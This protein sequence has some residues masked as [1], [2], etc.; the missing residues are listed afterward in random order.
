M[1]GETA[2]EKLVDIGRYISSPL[3]SRIYNL[4]D[5]P[6]GKVLSLHRLN[7]AYAS[8]TS[9]TQYTNFFYT[10]LEFLNIDLHINASDIQKIPSAGPLVVVANHP[11]GGLDGIILGAI[12]TT[13]RPD[14]KILGNYMLRHIPELYEFV[15]PIDPF[16]KKNSMLKNI[17][18][19]KQ[20]IDWLQ[21]GGALGTFP[22]GEVSHFKVSRAQVTDPPWTPHVGSL[23][24][25]TGAAVLPVFFDGRNSN[26]FH[27]LGLLHPR[28]RTIMLPRELLNKKATSIKVHIGSP[29]TFRT[30]S[31]FDTNQSMADYLRLCTYILKNRDNKPFS[32]NLP[33]LHP[34][35]KYSKSIVPPLSHTMLRREIERLTDEQ[36]LLQQGDISVYIARGDQIPQILLEIGRLR[37]KTFREAGEGT[38]KKVDLDAFD[39]SYLQLFMWN[40]AEQEIV[41]GYRLAPIDQIIASFGTQGLYTTTL[42]RFKNGFLQNLSPAL[43]LGRSFI[44]SHY[45][46][47]YNSLALLWRGIGEFIT[48]NPQY[49]ILF[50]PVSISNDYQTVSRNL[51]LQFLQ[52]SKV[53]PELSRYVKARNPAR[54][55]KIRGVDQRTLQS[56]FLTLEHVSA[57]VSEIEKDGKGVPILLRHYLKLNGTILSFN[58]DADFS[59][60]I[61]SLLIVDLRKTETKLLKRFMNEGGLKIFLKYHNIHTTGDNNCPMQEGQALQ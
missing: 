17:K 42:F 51:I 19:L 56:P 1:I 5:W 50:G 28:F 23:I 55:R 49:K 60:V 54:N 7:D 29:I 15:I 3:K 37:E 40:H 61:D 13:V 20:T 32:F 30:L 4:F 38:G 14:V 44:C 39:R 31:N 9:Q 58:V 43:E 10:C 46:K 53:N 8:I 57:L 59:H 18:P 47:K 33:F 21:K 22:A 45:Q 24:K 52:D 27:I 41:G 34:K 6:L 35:K 36:C 26:L 25:R 11:F 16:K 48:R 2:Q 12:L